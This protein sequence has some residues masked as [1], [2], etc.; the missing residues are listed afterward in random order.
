V[1]RDRFANAIDPVALTTL[2]RVL[3][4][5]REDQVDGNLRAVVERARNLLVTVTGL[6]TA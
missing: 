3:L 1:T 5:M 4:T 6:R 2:N